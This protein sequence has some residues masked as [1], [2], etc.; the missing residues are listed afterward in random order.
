MNKRSNLLVLISLG[1]LWSSFAAFTKVAA[2]AASPFFIAFSRLAIGGSLLYAVTTLQ[3]KPVFLRKNLKKYFIVGLVNSALP[4]TLFGLSAKYLDSGVVSIL[5]GA[6][7]MFEVLIA[8]FIFGQHV[9]KNSILGVMFGVIG[10][11]ITSY[12]NISGFDLA[13]NQIIA[14]G[15]ILLAT[16]SYAA[17]SHYINS[18]CKKIEAMTLATGSV[19]CAAL[20]LSPCLF[21][22]DFAVLADSKIISSLLGLG[23]IC[24]GIAY[25]F[26][27]KLTAEEGPRTAVSVV[28]LI[29]VF[30][31]IFGAIFFGEEISLS[32]II[33][34]GMILASMKFILNLSR[35]NFFKSKQAPIV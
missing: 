33:G 28:L 20:M 1:I 16:A 3:K 11:I 15:A 30:G 21:F 9:S 12:G 23:I 29:P 8:I 6:V 14:I 25:V 31:T 26:Y 34:C 13:L 22:T 7:P 18:H 35:D 4:F 17:A 32:K 5:D 2:E 10:I 19:L 24:T 27:F